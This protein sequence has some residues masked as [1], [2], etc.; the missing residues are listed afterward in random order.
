MGAWSFV[1]RRIEQAL[2]GLD[3]KAKRARYVGRAEAAATATG[4]V[5][6]QAEEQARLVGTKRLRFGRRKEGRGT[7]HGYRHHRA[8]PWANR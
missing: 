7:D 2:G 6:R 5:K 8:R 1:D 3:I 4:L